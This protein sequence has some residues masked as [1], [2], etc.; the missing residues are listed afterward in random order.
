MIRIA[1]ANIQG[2]TPYSPSKYYLPEKIGNEKAAEVE[3]RTWRERF[4]YQ[5]DGRV[6]IP[7]MAFKIA[8]QGAA[9]FL[10][11]KVPGRGQKTYAPF[12]KAAVLVMDPLVLPVKKDEVPGEQFYVPSDGVSGGSKRVMKT[13]GRVDAWGGDVK[14]YLFDETI[15]NRAFEE[16]LRTAGQFVGLGRFRPERGGFYGRFNVNKISWDEQVA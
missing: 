5:P 7:P 6:F 9:S 10:G 13:F 2:V 12:F 16:H 4:H 14:F 1:T 15:D 3:I 8:L 11:R